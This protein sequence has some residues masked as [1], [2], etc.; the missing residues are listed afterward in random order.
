MSKLFANIAYGIT[1]CYR[2]ISQQK[3]CPCCAGTGFDI[4]DAKFPYQLLRCCGCAILTR[5]PT[6]SPAAMSA[7]YETEYSQQG[8]TTDLP[9]D[10]DLAA[11]L[12]SNFEGSEKDARSVI[13]LFR[14]LHLKP[15]AR[16]CD[17][18]A[19]WGYMTLQ[20]L[21]AGYDAVG[22]E[23]SRN[24]AS[25]AQKF[26]V[27]IET[28]LNFPPGSFDAVFSSH[29]LEHVPDPL[30][31][32]RSQL[33]LVRPGGFVIGFTPNGSEERR[34]TQFESFHR[35]WGKVHPSLLTDEFIRKNFDRQSFLV[36][37]NRASEAIAKWDRTSRVE[38]SV[39]GGEL[40]FILRKQ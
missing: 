31:V 35:H 30:N 6:E 3:K 4:V 23:I 19:N 18:G 7:F 39:E 16:I 17:Y 26:N 9:T 2:R 10:S 37:C 29:V 1:G 14:E 32:I 33:A 36:T 40:V 25:F 13:D 22:Y 11:L 28:E 15:S 8:L 20:F 21:R 24:R 5:F 34:R 38:T 12:N 27:K